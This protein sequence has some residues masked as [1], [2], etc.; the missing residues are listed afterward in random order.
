MRYI[1]V[2][3]AVMRGT[4]RLSGAM[5]GA[6]IAA[7]ILVAAWPSGAACSNCVSSVVANEAIY[8]SLAANEGSF[9]SA[10]LV[11]GVSYA[12]NI[13]EIQ[14]SGGKQSIHVTPTTTIDKHGQVGSIADIRPGVHIVV[15]GVVRDGQKV[16]LTIEIK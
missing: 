5:L 6:M 8:S 4:Q 11:S 3:V 12:Q 9:T 10:G 15:N 13:V 16:A 7:L 1:D 2:M 14:V